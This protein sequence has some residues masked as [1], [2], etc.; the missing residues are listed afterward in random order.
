[1]SSISAYYTIVIFGVA[2]A[3]NKLHQFAPLV[4]TQAIC[5]AEQ[6]VMRSSLKLP[7]YIRTGGFVY[8]FNF[9][10]I[11]MSKEKWLKVL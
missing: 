4:L 11:I 2:R 9:S 3:A 10:P 6:S 1:M 7:F 5:P 8:D